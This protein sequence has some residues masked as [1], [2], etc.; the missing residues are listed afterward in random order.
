V[1]KE[2]KRFINPL[3]R[4]TVEVETKR[5][6]VQTTKPEQP[7]SSA[8]TNTSTA[9]S[10]ETLTAPR[11][12]EQPAPVPQV[13]EARPS[14]K[15]SMTHPS[16][17]TSTAQEMAEL[18]DRS[19]I[20][21]PF[22]SERDVPPD[23]SLAEMLGREDVMPY[24]TSSATPIYRDEPPLALRRNTLI[25]QTLPLATAPSS[26]TQP[27]PST[28]HSD[29][30]SIPTISYTT[31][32]EPTTSTSTYTE[33][34]TSSPRSQDDEIVEH[35]HRYTAPPPSRRRR[36]AQAFENTHERITLWIDKRLKQAF[37][38]LAYEQE[39]SKTALL[40]EAMADLLNK[41]K[42]RKWK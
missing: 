21:E 36:G 13:T 12:A 8:S 26:E 31:S 1:P 25:D 34:N 6:E 42:S 32:S 2:S 30:F 38:E 33:P 22:R 23:I 3:L 27:F 15:R 41:Y 5:E 29:E 37:E 18:P 24:T 10:M 19:Q 7:V 20:K 28:S 40:N 17:D 35:E 4:P 14:A 39:I 11:I 9:T 16:T